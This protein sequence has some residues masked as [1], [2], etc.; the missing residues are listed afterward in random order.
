M[1]LKTRPV[2]ITAAASPTVTALVTQ[3]PLGA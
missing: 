2:F 3:P 1:A